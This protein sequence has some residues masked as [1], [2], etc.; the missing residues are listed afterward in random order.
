MPIRRRFPRKAK[1][2]LE[3]HSEST[4]GIVEQWK[5]SAHAVKGVDCYSCHQANADDPATFNHYGHKIA[6][7]VTPN[8][9]ARCHANEVKQFEQ[10]HHAAAAKFIGSLDNMLGEIVEGF[11]EV[12]KIFY[13]EFVPQAELLMPGVTTDVMNSDYHKWTKGL[14]KEQLQQQIDFYKE[15]FDRTDAKC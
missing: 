6:V 7:I 13:T 1:A 12:A 5:S 3:C 14:S 10:S 11:F 15:R 4:P 2:C 9:Y 8:Y